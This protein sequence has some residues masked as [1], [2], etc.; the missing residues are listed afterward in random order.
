MRSKIEAVNVQMGDDDRYE[1]VISQLRGSNLAAEMWADAEHI[2]EETPGKVWTVIL[3]SDD[4]PPMPAAWCAS[5]ITPD[6]VLRCSDNYERR[7]A[8]RR[9]GLYRLAYNWRHV[10]RVLPLGLAAVT[11]LY[12]QPLAIHE[13]D[14]WYRTGTGGM[15]PHGHKWW[16]LRRR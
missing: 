7:G 5:Q 15:S 16:E 9:H 4:H 2:L 10:T 6:G 1:E 13:A 8:G 3:V 14:G 12:A 11:Y